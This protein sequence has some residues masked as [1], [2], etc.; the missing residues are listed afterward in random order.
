MPKEMILIETLPKALTYFFFPKRTKIA[1]LKTTSYLNSP[2]RPHGFDHRQ[3]HCHPGDEQK[4]PDKA[5][6]QFP[7]STLSHLPGEP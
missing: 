4:N 1:F 2:A 5:Q 3:H 6:F 7:N